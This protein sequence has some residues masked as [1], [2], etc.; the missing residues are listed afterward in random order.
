M[1]M[2][3]LSGCALL[4]MLVAMGAHAA[5][6]KENTEWP[7]G[8]VQFLLTKAEQ[9]AWKTVT[10]DEEAKKFID[11]FWARRDPTPNTPANEFR[12]GF[13]QRVKLADDRFRAPGTP[14]SKTDQGK[15]F[16]LLGGPTKI[17]RSRS[18][19]T[20]NILAPPTSRRSGDITP[21]ADNTPK[22][23]WEY[24]QAKMNIQLGTP[25]VVLGFID[26]YGQKDWK[27]ERQA[28]TD[29]SALFEKVAE[30]FVVLPDLREMPAIGAAQAAAA[31]AEPMLTLKTDALRLAVDA[32]RAGGA[33]SP[34][35]FVSY[36]EFVTTDGEHF[37]PVQLYASAGLDPDTPVTFFGTVEKAAGGEAV[38]AF[39]D[40]ATTSPTS[41]G[42]FV[43]RSLTLPPGEY[44]GTFGIAAEGKPM[45]VVSTPM[46]VAG[47]D[48][49]AS[50]VS[51]LILS[52]HVYTLSEAQLPT[53]PFAFGGLKVVPKSDLV[54]RT[55][56]ELWYFFELRNPQLDAATGKPKLM[57]KLTVSGKAADGAPVK[58]AAPAEETPAQELKDVP[59][60]WAVGQAMPLESFTPGEYTLAVKVTNTVNSQSWDLQGKFRI[61]E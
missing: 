28:Q 23:M 7:K 2:I 57:V 10:T 14:G 30:S 40:P 56:D 39:E 8:P 46:T 3:R 24:E 43:A 1:K 21:V 19:A 34:N 51:P 44:R 48:K 55:K 38:A 17:R 27:L 59:G 12:D 26:Q 31:S 41:G 37:V 45:S 52:N 54:F 15:V 11:L 35:V 36:G 5:L 18:V 42:V 61:V 16:V 13:E 32:L 60:H 33:P 9:N 29:Q 20:P 4:A 25:K 58:M 6:S 49:D 47:V 22:E 53:D 50:A